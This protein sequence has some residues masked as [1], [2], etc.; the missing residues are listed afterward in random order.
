MKKKCQPLGG[1][2]QP[3]DVK[4]T[5]LKETTSQKINHVQQSESQKARPPEYTW[6]T[7]CIST[8]THAYACLIGT[9]NTLL[10]F[11]SIIILNFASSMITKYS[12][13]DFAVFH[14]FSIDHLLVCVTITF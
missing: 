13:L 14:W 8:L 7:V 5:R 12:S 10:F 6:H 1:L 2:Q 4:E 11:V 3:T 9:P